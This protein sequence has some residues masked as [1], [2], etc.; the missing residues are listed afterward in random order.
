MTPDDPTIP[1]ALKPRRGVITQGR[2]VGAPQ[3]AATAER[4]GGT[5]DPA[6]LDSRAPGGGRRAVGSVSRV[7]RGASAADGP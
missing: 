3:V 2:S 7:A 1:A 5:A 6:D 4:E